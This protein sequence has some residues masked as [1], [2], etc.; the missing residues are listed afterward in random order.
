MLAAWGDS[1]D[2]EEASKEEEEAVTL[3]ARSATDF[4]E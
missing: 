1:T 3:M 2:E 4:D